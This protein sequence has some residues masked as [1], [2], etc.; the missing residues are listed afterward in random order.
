MPGIKS[1]VSET[2]YG[3][4]GTS[5]VNS[6]VVNKTQVY[7]KNETNPYVQE[8]IDLIQS[9][10]AGKPLNELQGVA[11][12]TMTAILGRMAAYSGQTVTWEQALNSAENTMPRGLTESSELTVPPVP[13]PGKYKVGGRA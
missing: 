4:E 8:H 1:D 2:V 5:R 13:V 10:R 3:S 9:I 12:S 7:D 11:E 6:Y